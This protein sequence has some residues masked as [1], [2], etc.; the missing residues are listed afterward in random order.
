MKARIRRRW[1]LPVLILMAV[2]PGTFSLTAGS[3]GTP[4]G[5]RH[6][7][8][9]IRARKADKE[10]Q[11]R[12]A[13]SR[14]FAIE[15]AR[16]RALGNNDAAYEC[17]RRAV[18]IDPDNDPAAF[19]L[20]WYNVAFYD[21]INDSAPYPIIELMRPY[22]AHHPEDLTSLELFAQIASGL[23]KYDE[24]LECL[25]RI[26]KNHPDET[27]WLYEM[28]QLEGALGHTDSAIMYLNI[29]EME[30]GVQ[31][32]ITRAKIDLDI[33]SEHP[34][35][36]RM[37]A[38]ADALIKA[39]PGDAFSYMTKGALLN[40][41]SMPDSVVVYGLKAASLDPTALEPLRY[42]IFAYRA[43]EDTVAFYNMFQDIVHRDYLSFD[44]QWSF[45]EEFR[46]GIFSDAVDGRTEPY[47]L[48]DTVIARH[49]NFPAPYEFRASLMALR[50]D[51][52]NAEKDLL[53]CYDLD[54]GNA[55]L[56]QQIISTAQ[57]CDSDN[58]TRPIRM[59]E[60]LSATLQPLLPARP[61]G[62]PA[63]ADSVT[64]GGDFSATGSESAT[65]AAADDS[66]DSA[67]TAVDNLRGF[68]FIGM[69]LYAMDGNL[70]RATETGTLIA[71]SIR[72]SVTIGT[73]MGPDSIAAL[74]LSASE[75]GMLSTLEQSLGD[76]CLLVGDTVAG[77][78]AYDR[79]LSYF[80]D[81][82]SV[83]NN[84]AFLLAD[85]N[86]QLDRAASMI[87][88][89]VRQQPENAMFLD[90]QA[91]VYFRQGLYR[92]ALSTQESALTAAENPESEYFEHYGDILSKTGETDKAVENW[93]KSL[94]LLEKS[95]TTAHELQEATRQKRLRL[96]RLKIE[97]REYL[98]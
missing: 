24:A 25:R 17:F 20:G 39:A 80:P 75:Q 45:L 14:Y 40:Q 1:W 15:G 68:H 58:Y 49:K 37:L 19:R 70:P 66:S 28:S 7:R 29:L 33:R 54:P 93:E 89:A 42:L 8:K 16:Q 97:R 72:P 26:Y 64:S 23:G 69:S 84:Y 87:S 32:E 71:R 86:E 98:E 10:S 48:I 38:E 9:E 11:R 61:D 91:W 73:P 81:D 90:T 60:Q 88:N 94:D 12:A 56:A 65:D 78:K 21:D 50:D 13:K 41:L 92:M 83:L 95:E 82:A 63:A 79:A 62:T 67:D 2:L 35:T 18:H 96:L 76:A 30:E 57:I 47:A 3:K 6:P 44:E 51:Y 4:E 77:F 36:A 5:D 34:D 43:A 53:T 31:T 55:A 74:K 59:Y 22:V 85:R 52:K 46:L 27:Q